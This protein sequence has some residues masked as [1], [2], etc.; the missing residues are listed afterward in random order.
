MDKAIAIFDEL[1]RLDAMFSRENILTKDKILFCIYR[2]N[3]TPRE[4][5]QLMN[6]AKGNL[7]NYCKELISKKY[8]TKLQSVGGREISYQITEL[9]TKRITQIIKK[10]EGLFKNETV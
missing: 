8:L 4:I 5:M 1:I 10:I 7:A 9:G 2:G 6:I 3:D